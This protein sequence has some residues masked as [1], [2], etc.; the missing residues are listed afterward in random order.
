MPPVSFV[1]IV[2]QTIMTGNIDDLSLLHRV[3]STIES[4][5]EES[6][7]M[8]KLHTACQGLYNMT[9]Q[10]LAQ[11]G[12]REGRKQQKHQESHDPVHANAWNESS[13][14][15]WQHLTLTEADWNSVL[16]VSAIVIVS[17]DWCVDSLVGV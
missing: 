15:D 10:G 17:G 1:V 3:V 14:A 8:Q 9:Q 5:T 6:P 16:N 7:S 13:G 11:A 4:A 12:P 2:S